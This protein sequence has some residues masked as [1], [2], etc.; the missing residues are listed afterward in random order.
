MRTFLVAVACAALVVG[1]TGA[2]IAVLV[3]M[4]DS[5]TSIFELRPGECFDL[6]EF[7]DDGSR[8]AEWREVDTV[9]CADAH[10]VEVL[11]T[12]QLDPDQRRPRPDD[13]ELFETVDAT[14]AD[15]RARADQ[16][17]YGLLPIVPNPAV[18]EPRG[19]PYLCVAIPYGGD[20]TPGSILDRVVP[21]ERLG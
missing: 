4:S 12:G 18:W 15:V 17:G 13:A 10:T 21:G 8:P 14:C 3:A 9:D 7:G 1:A 5:A 19:G 16:L 2:L 11:V 6:P 20:P